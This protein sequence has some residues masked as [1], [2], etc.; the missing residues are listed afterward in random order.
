MKTAD[1]TP[2]QIELFGSYLWSKLHIIKDENS[3]WIIPT[4][5]RTTY[6]TVTIK[7]IPVTAHIIAY[8]YKTGPIENG[9]IVCHT[10]DYKPCCRPNHLFLGTYSDNRVDYCSKK[11]IREGIIINNRTIIELYT[12]GARLADIAKQFSIGKSRAR[13]ILTVNGVKIR[14]SGARL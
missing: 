10:C 11:R 12:N 4:I 14:L 13:N 8:L 3:C 1:I 9:L 7:G 2:E 6:A 5:N